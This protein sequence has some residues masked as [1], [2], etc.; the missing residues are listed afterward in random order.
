[1]MIARVI[2]PMAVALFASAAV[3]AGNVKIERGIAYAAD[4]ANEYRRERCK[5]DVKV[6][7]AGKDF[8]TIVWFHGGGLTGGGRHFIPIDENIAQVAV[9]YRLMNATNGVHGADCIADAAAAVA[10]TVK[11]I[12]SYGGDPRKVY[13]S[14]MSAG[15]YLTMMVGMDP[16]WLA[17]HGVNNRDLAGLAP[18]SGQATKHFAVREFAG[19]GDPQFRPVVDDLA[20]LKYVSAELPPIISICGEPGYEWKGRAEENKL[21]IGSCKALGHKWAR[22]VELPFCDHGRAYTAGLPYVE[23]FVKGQLP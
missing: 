16:K 22:Y 11:N 17:A 8:K 2:M 12:A 13:V 6:P 3:L 18:V 7:N 19:D 23:M 21:L 14:G 9:D 4:D 5:L 1:M 10:W 20:P 15:G